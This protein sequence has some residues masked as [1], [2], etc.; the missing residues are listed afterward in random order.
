MATSSTHG[1]TNTP[2]FEAWC[3]MRKRCNNPKHQF[4]YRYGGRGIVVCDRWVNSFVN[5]L[6]DMGK[7]PEGL[8]LERINNNGNYGPDNC[9]WATWTEQA[10]NKHINSEYGVPGIRFKSS[11]YEVQIKVQGKNV[12]LGR[13]VELVAAIHARKEGE[14][15]YWREQ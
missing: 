10:R 5:F 9:K 8:T 12:Y 13:F 2:E 3:G 4:Y 6:E 7:R 1:K 14:L 11:K 15:Q